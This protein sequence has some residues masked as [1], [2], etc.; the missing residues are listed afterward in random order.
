M[1]NVRRGSDPSA[2]F[3]KTVSLNNVFI[4]SGDYIGFA[5]YRTLNY[6]KQCTM[7]YGNYA[8]TSLP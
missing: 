8:S 6:V 3:R 4:L 2:F 5:K 7:A 1:L